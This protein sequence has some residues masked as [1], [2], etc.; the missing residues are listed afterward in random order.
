MKTRSDVSNSV[1]DIAVK[2][3]LSGYENIDETLGE[4]SVTACMLWSR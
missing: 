2:R 1:V 3:I 4:F